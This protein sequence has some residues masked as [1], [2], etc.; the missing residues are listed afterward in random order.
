MWDILELERPFIFNIWKGVDRI[1][2]KNFTYCVPQ[3]KVMGL[4]QR[5]VE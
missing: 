1:F 5:E 4:N 2:F 3:K